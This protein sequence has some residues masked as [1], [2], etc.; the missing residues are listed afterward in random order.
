MAI[1]TQ[2]YTRNS[3][4]GDNDPL[5]GRR[6]IDPRTIDGKNSDMLDKQWERMLINRSGD[7]RAV[8]LPTES[9]YRTVQQV[10][11]P[12]LGEGVAQ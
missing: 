2:T 1:D 8:A 10:I 11:K 7:R 12:N 5:A 4:V 6:N 3:R 9:D